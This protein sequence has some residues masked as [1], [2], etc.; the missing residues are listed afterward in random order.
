MLKQAITVV[1][2][3]GGNWLRKQ[4][5]VSSKRKKKTPQKPTL[6]HVVS[7]DNCASRSST[8]RKISGSGSGLTFFGL[9]T[10]Q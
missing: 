2:N 9:Q 8:R 7:I 6:R 10:R 5:N 4:Q 1:L 3:D